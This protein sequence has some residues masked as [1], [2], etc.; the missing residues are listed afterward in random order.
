ML[1]FIPSFFSGGPIVMPG[2]FAS[3][4]NPVI[5]FSVLANTEIRLAIPAFVIHIFDPFKI[6]LSPFFLLQF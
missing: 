2:E 3:T 1:P 5:P 4:A 6:H